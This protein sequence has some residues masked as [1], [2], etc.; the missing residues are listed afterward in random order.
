MVEQCR[1]DLVQ[2]VDPAQLESVM[3]AGALVVDIRPA[4]HRARE[5]E[6]PGAVVIE[7]TVL[8]WRLDPSSPHRIPEA[9]D[10]ERHIVIVCT[11]GYSS[12][13]AAHTLTLLGMPN[14]TDLRGGY[15]AWA[16]PAR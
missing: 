14:A 6:L 4:D 10:P 8:E 9:V 3:A 16:A 13:L 7:R 11:E 2:R 15:R 1:R 12:T 5:G